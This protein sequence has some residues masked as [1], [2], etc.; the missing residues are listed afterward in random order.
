MKM[1][2]ITLYIIHKVYWKMKHKEKIVKWNKFF[3]EA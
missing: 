2:I 3:K 1:T